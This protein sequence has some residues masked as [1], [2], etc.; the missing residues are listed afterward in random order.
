VENLFS[1]GTLQ[2]ESVQLST[3]G[4]KLEGD[5]DCLVGYKLSFVTIED[6]AVVTVSGMAAHPII[7]YTNNA[8]DTVNG[9]VFTITADELQ[10][11]D[12]YEV[13]DYERISI[14]LQSGKTAWV[15]VGRADKSNAIARK[16]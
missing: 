13:D 4:R 6:E 15:Y 10:Q 3:F 1:Y 16:A 9:T 11:A 5:A 8:N 12:E 7:T 14:Q 2:L